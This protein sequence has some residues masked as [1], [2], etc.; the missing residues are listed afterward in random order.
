[1]IFLDHTTSTPLLTEVFEVMRPYYQ[2]RFAV[3]SGQYAA[4]RQ[5]RKD[6]ESAREQL[7]ALLGC[8]PAELVFT[9]GGTEA[10]NLAVR[11]VAEAS[12]RRGDHIITTQAE[13]RCVLDVCQQLERQGFRVTYLPVDAAG[14]VDLAALE[15][16][17]DDRTI[18]V[19]VMLANNEVGTLQPM[20]EVVRLVKA[21]SRA[22][23][24]YTDAAAAGG[25]LEVSVERL[26][27]DLLSLSAHKVYGPRG[28]GLLYVKRLVPL[29]AQILGGNQ[30]RNR[31]AGTEYVAGIVGMARAFELAYADLDARCAQLQ[32]LTGRLVEGLLERVDDTVLA[33]PADPAARLPH[34]ATLCFRYVD[35]EAMVLNLD[36]QGIAAASG[37]ACASATFDPSHVLRAM[38][39]PKELAHGNLRIGTGVDN[40]PADIDRALEIIPRVVAR[41]REISPLGPGAGQ[42]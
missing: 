9:S 14:A 36:V 38:G 27:V 7:A 29:Q 40:T 42:R 35:G 3:A 39:V 1:M 23:P 15:Q 31:R 5:A 4:A 34:V 25:V 26:G 20:A 19:A 11:G 22:I 28:A 16:A 21:K 41:L 2:E 6:I 37:S 12:R 30:E 33:G 13:H 24:V 32:A 10:A 17:L 8:R 18:L